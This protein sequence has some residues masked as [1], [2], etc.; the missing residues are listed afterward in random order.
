MLKTGVYEQALQRLETHL[1]LLKDKPEES[2]QSTLAALWF[3]AAGKPLSAAATIGKHRPP[4][5]AEQLAE[6]HRLLEL[7]LAGTPLAHITGR[8]QFMGLEMLAG[9]EALIPRKETEIL[10]KQ[11]VQI[12]Q[13][14]YRQD[15]RPQVIDLCTGAGN[16]AVVLALASSKAKIYASDISSDCLSLAQR[17]F[18]M[19]QVAN[20]VVTVL[21]DLLVPF[22]HE[23]LLGSVDLI[24]CN[25]P[26]IS[27]SKVEG[28]EAEIADHEPVQAFDGGP[29]GIALINRLIQDA[30]QFLRRGGW[31]VLE[32][33]LGQG[34]A[35]IK[36]MTKKQAF[37]KII[38]IAD[39]D[40]NIRVLAAQR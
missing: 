3:A 15:R 7:R 38:P 9:P 1:R 36:R 6:L 22:A 17:N 23:E 2:A 16:V 14:Q 28:M 10:A 29:F 34:P 8:Q 27:T 32:I 35:L 19:H 30:P 25:P 40:N 5:Q 24:T 18:E 20:R 33:G 4:L 26:Y 39:Q 37:T 12:L 31:L 13:S 11:A 21:G